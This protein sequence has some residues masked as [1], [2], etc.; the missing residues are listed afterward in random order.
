MSFTVSSADSELKG[1]FP[2]S[3]TAVFELKTGFAAKSTPVKIN[4]NPRLSK[5]LFIELIPPDFT[6]AS[7]SNRKDSSK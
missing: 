6:S 1:F 4:V 2:V 5:N 7:L 3:F